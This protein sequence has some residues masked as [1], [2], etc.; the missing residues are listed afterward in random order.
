MKNLILLSILLTF[1]FLPFSQINMSQLGY[2]DIPTLHSTELN[3]IW[4][5]T[6]EM[7]N[8]YAIVGTMDGT[9]IVDV[10]DPANP[11][12]ISWFPGLNSIWRDMKVYDDY[13][14]VTT[15]ANEGLLIID[16]SPLPGSTTLPT[17]TYN[18]PSGNTWQSA[19]NL[20]Q[21]D[22][23]V[24]IF[25]ANRG[26]GGVIILDVATDPM[27]PIEVGGFDPWY[28]HDG[29]V[30]ND[31]GYFSHVND[32]FFSIVDLSNKTSVGLSEVYGSLTTSNV[33]THN[34]WLSDNG[35]YLFTT[36]EVTDGFIDSYDISDPTNPLFLDKIQ[37]SPGNNIIPH[38]TH[39]LNNYLVT[40][41][42]TDGVVVHDAS[43]PS[44]LVEIANFDTS[45]NY[46]GG[47]FNGCWGVYP[48]FS[49][50][51]IIA[52]DIEEGLYILELSPTLSSYLQGT[53]TNVGTGQPINN[54]LIEVLT[55]T[56]TD[57][58]D[59]L[60]DYSIGTTN[61]GIFEVRYSAPGFYADTL[62]TT[63][64]NGVIVTQNVA[65][66][67]IPL[68]TA[69]ITVVD[70]ITGLPVE[71]ANVLIEH[72]QQS[73]EEVTDAS[74]EA[75]IDLFYEDNYHITAGKWGY[76]TNCVQNVMLTTSNSD[77]QLPIEE[78][79]YDDFTFDFGW[80]SSATSTAGLWVREVPVGTQASGQ[81]ANPFSDDLGD[82]STICFVSGNSA[83]TVGGDD[84]D[85]GA[86]TLV[87]PIFD[88]SDF[89]N[90]EI[91]FSYW[92]FNGFGSGTPNDYMN[93][94]LSNGIETQL[95]TSLELSNATLSQWTNYTIEVTQFM[96]ATDQMQLTFEAADIGS[97]HVMEAGVDHF[98]IKE[99]STAGEVL[100][101]IEEIAIYPNPASESLTIKGINAGNIHIHDLS[102]RLVFSTNI[103]ETIELSGLKSGLYILTL[104]DQ[105]G[106]IVKIQKQ[107]IQ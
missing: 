106:T 81:I 79:I 4:G 94:S 56:I 25:G 38:N 92:F 15:E 89:T 97:G 31:T 19:H 58:T 2:L 29:F 1:P 77:Y 52:S 62:S 45:P 61:Q 23:Y 3:D 76:I 53:V 42:Y 48:F 86:V 99:L 90:P 26:N 96:A 85:D 66:E 10:S 83:S 27:N 16:L 21:A 40:S 107:E 105:N 17:A 37:S 60:G 51:I 70:D 54:A 84:I 82:C 12:E 33:F 34:A 59:V 9:S 8:E 28:C 46:S 80:T 44:S 103:S 55:T 63:F 14:Y 6:D 36:D 30:R 57:N 11:V 50:G 102:G 13:A 88:L 93:I 68:F 7:G 104:V 41:Y 22:G 100:K 20:Y 74:G 49:S 67:Q 73:F 5:Y 39:V 24:Y 71:N 64:T 47:T 43:D 72:T 75:H 69:T 18:G 91:N 65:L 101:P 32:G 87:S 95:I 98:L 78:G 35:Q